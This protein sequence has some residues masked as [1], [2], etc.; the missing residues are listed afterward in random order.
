MSRLDEKEQQFQIESSFQFLEKI[1]APLTLK[2]FCYPYGG[3]HSFNETTER[4]LDKNDC[5]FSFNLEQRD[6]IK[7]D[8]LIRPQA[9]PRFDCNQFKYGKVRKYNRLNSPIN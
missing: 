7:S 6:I 2:T 5:L 8:L 3:F 4:L 1:T 9:L